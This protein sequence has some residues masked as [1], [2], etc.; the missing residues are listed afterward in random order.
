MNK[1]KMIKLL[2]VSTLMLSVMTG[3]GS[4]SRTQDY[5]SLVTLDINPSIQ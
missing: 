5:T 1:M 4:G 3:C 2:G